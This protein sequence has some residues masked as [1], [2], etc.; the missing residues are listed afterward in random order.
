[1][2]RCD[3]AAMQ[4]AKK[5]GG[6]LF[7]RV[8]S[9]AC[10]ELHRQWARCHAEHA[11]A[12]LPVAGSSSESESEPV[13]EIVLALLYAALTEGS[14]AGWAPC[15]GIVKSKESILCCRCS[16]LLKCCAF[17]Q[18]IDQCYVK[19]VAFLHKRPVKLTGL[20]DTTQAQG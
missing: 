10:S 19:W 9:D 13:A 6:A 5:V 20:P 14:A 2:L 3:I 8:P 1:M 7:E 17:H 15:V 4:F 18:S 16:L 12:S 11:A